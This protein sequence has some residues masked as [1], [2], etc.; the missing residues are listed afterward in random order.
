MEKELVAI[1]T[2]TMNAHFPKKTGLI[3]DAYLNEF[4]TILARE[5]ADAPKLDVDKGNLATYIKL[6]VLVMAMVKLYKEI[7][8]SKYEIGEFIYRTADEYYRLSPMKKWIQKKLFF[9]R[10]NKRQIIRRQEI[11]EQLENGINGFQIKYIEGTNPNEFGVDYLKCGICDYFARKN[12][13]EYVKY[14]CLVDYAIMKNMG[15]SFLRTTTLGNGGKKCDFRF[16]KEGKIEAGWPPFN[17]KEFN[18][19]EQAGPLGL[20]EVSK[21][22]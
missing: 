17:L 14:C 3:K 1:F 19:N 21:D 4:K 13:F 11:S 9:S 20:L 12:L 18:R 10:L 5:M 8:M 7:G 6:S 22:M 16:A 15:I 2:G